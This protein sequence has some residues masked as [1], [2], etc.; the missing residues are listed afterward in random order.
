MSNA[1]LLFHP[2]AYDTSGPQLM[3]RHSAGESFMR[4]FLRYADVDR[5]YF[6]NTGP[7]SPQQAETLL[8]RIT[9]ITKP[10]TWIGRTDIGGLG[11]AGCLFFPAPAN[12]QEGWNRRIVGAQRYSVT[13]ITHT[14]A[15]AQV[16]EAVANMVLAPVEPWDALICTSSA[17][18]DS[19]TS[20]IDDVV[21]YLSG[22][23]GPIRRPELRLETI[24]L[25]V[26]TEDFVTTPED[27]G[28]WRAELGI[29][30]DAIVALYMGRYSIHT[31]MNP[32]P[33]G[34]ALSRAAAQSGKEVHWVLAGW[35]ADH[36]M[37]AF[38]QAVTDSAPGVTVHFVD[39]RRPEARF[40]IWS[41]A[42]LFVSFS[43]NIQETFG[44][45]PVEAMAA[46]IPCV[47][48]DWNGYK[49]TVRNGL[50]GFR[51]PTYAPAAGM[52]A[53]LAFRFFNNLDT[54][55]SYIAGASHLV[56][57]DLV[58]ATRAIVRLIEDPELR[59]R[60][61]ETARERAR[62]DFDWA[63][64]I[65]R[66]QALWA[67]LN[68]VRAAATTSTPIKD[69]PWRPDP[70]RVFA[71]YPTQA[72]HPGM[73]FAAAEGVDPA[74]AAAFLNSPASNFVRYVT[75]SPDEVVTILNLLQANGPMTNEAIAEAMPAH[76]RP[77]LRRG[78]LWLLKHG[79]VTLL[80]GKPTPLA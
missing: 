44:L 41:V 55:E 27:R 75:P 74:A 19:L 60:I 20:Q 7:T 67:E 49:D 79:F 11:K 30:E 18:K 69:N 76:R 53:D 68:R 57:V 38:K 4:G 56:A 39:G 28:K 21:E 25:G 8:N 3:G 73:L 5:F 47:I 2:D 58:E 15:T 14:T 48:A 70:F 36:L 77:S 71:N 46:G 62:R 66:Y 52:G 12:V 65:P 42:D 32:S 22:R 33:M 23:L 10:V 13:G 63:A 37:D 6:W 50:D 1:A 17:V 61:G 51:I 40:S 16:M 59:R 43:D 80:N 34:M 31:K 24:P 35:A 9:P 72:L 54:Y 45:T 29:P 64:I 78:V 26:N